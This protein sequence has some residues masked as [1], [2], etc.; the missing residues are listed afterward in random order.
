MNAGE[1]AEMRDWITDC[2]WRDLTPDEAEALSDAEV[3]EGI[4]ATY[5]GGVD[6]FLA[7]SGSDR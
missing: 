7:A 2:T 4:A 1:I 6:G 3:I 5:P